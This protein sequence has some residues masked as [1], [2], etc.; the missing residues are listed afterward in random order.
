FT[1]NAIS[2]TSGTSSEISWR[3][4][5]LSSTA[6]KVTP[7]RLPPGRARLA[8]RPSATGSP[9]PVKTIGIV[10]VAA[11]AARDCG[12]TTA[13]RDHVDFAVD[14]IGGHCREPAVATLRP[15]VF[16]QHVLSI[17]E[18]CS[19]SPWRKAVTYGAE[20]SRGAPTQIINDRS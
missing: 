12:I 9:Q 2:L 6:K 14:E 10:E 13:R 18:A 19:L 11:F 16:G 17:D 4:L 15:P 8:T 7:V 20:K 3:R 1:S 5:G